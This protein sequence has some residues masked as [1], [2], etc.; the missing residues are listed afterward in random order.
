MIYGL[1]FV[2]VLPAEKRPEWH[3]DLTP[4]CSRAFTSSVWRVSI[5]FLN[6]S[7]IHNDF[8]IRQG[9]RSERDTSSIPGCLLR[10]VT[11]EL[12]MIATLS[13]IRALLYM[14][15]TC[16]WRQAIK[17]SRRWRVA[18]SWS[19]RCSTIHYRAARDVCSFSCFNHGCFDSSSF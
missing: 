8:D 14:S 12:P 10:P 3:Q 13:F 4:H 18:G 16:V 1:H 19:Q 7:V 11:D 15:F 5:T 17:T 2:R 6:C 9:F